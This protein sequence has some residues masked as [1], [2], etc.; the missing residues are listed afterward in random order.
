MRDVQDCLANDDLQEL[1]LCV[2]GLE[3]ALFGLNRRV[4]GTSGRRQ[5]LQGIRNTL[6]P[7]G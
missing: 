1:D 4:G 5:P 6:L 2:S 7:Q 3:E